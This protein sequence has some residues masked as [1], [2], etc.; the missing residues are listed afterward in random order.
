MGPSHSTVGD[1][2]RHK[3]EEATQG[4]NRLGDSQCRVRQ[5]EHNQGLHR[6]GSRPPTRRGSG[7]EGTYGGST[8]KGP[9]DKETS[10]GG[11]APPPCQE[12]KAPYRSP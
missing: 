11:T 10:D 5:W 4:I 7:L 2:G 9:T 3:R 6:E 12:T 8:G 1:R